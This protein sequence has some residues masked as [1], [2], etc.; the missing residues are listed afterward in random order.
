MIIKKRCRIGITT[1]L[2]DRLNYWRSKHPTLRNWKVL[3]RY[4]TKTEAQRAEN[5]LARRNFCVA[6]PGGSGLERAA[7]YV[8]YFQY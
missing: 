2:R 6:S 1:D 5:I 3:G 8:Y 7:W 4:N